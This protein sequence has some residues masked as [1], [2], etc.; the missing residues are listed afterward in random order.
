[1]IDISALEKLDPAE[2]K[3]QS[4][5][6][7]GTVTFA[8]LVIPSG[9][10]GDKAWVGFKRKKMTYSLDTANKTAVVSDEL[11]N[12]VKA[13][14]EGDKSDPIQ[15]DF[16]GDVSVRVE[17]FSEGGDK[18]KPKNTKVTV[19]NHKTGK[20]TTVLD[21]GPEQAMYLPSPNGQYL[22]LCL[23]N[24]L[25]GPGNPPLIL[26]INNQGE[27]VSKVTVE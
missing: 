22:A 12:F 18:F 9:W 8:P 7:A 3:E 6:V 16:P 10:E 2:K 20:E 23:G 14:K 25:P 17:Q 4:L 5:G 24:V 15:F 11:L 13:K 1:K 21:K 27:V 19:V 26:V